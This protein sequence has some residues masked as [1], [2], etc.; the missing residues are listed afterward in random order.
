MFM[1]E[2]R[3][4]RSPLL[5]NDLPVRLVMIADD[6]SV[7]RFT[8]AGADCSAMKRTNPNVAKP[9]RGWH[10]YQQPMGSFGQVDVGDISHDGTSSCRKPHK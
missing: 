8:Q 6:P 4:N 10:T 7:D 9:S 5:I 3:L 1:V 2:F